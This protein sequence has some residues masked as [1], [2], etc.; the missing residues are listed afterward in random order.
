MP[1]I[2]PTTPRHTV[3]IRSY[4]LIL[5]TYTA[6]HM[7]RGCFPEH[8]ASPDR[9]LSFSSDLGEEHI[10]TSARTFENVVLTTAPR[11]TVRRDQVLLAHH[12]LHYGEKIHDFDGVLQTVSFQLVV[13]SHPM[14][15]DS[16]GTD[17]AGRG[18]CAHLIRGN[19]ARFTE[20]KCTR[21]EP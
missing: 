17:V 6:C 15:A 13:S 18:A 1:V 4:R 14:P 9:F 7:F 19:Q 3:E 16:R 8:F 20:R 21:T 10:H 2:L 5:F 11:H 12:T